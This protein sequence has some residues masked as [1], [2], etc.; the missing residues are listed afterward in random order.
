MPFTALHADLGRLNATLH[1]LGHGL[2]WSQIHKA[3]PRPPL[4]CPE[5]TWGLH[6]KVSKYG[7]RYFC[8]DP[9]RPPSCSL[10]NES[11]EHHMLKLEMATAIRDAGW[12][13]ELEVPA[14][15]GS[16]RADV[17]ATS[18]DGSQRMAWEA[19]LSPITVDDIRARTE[20]YMAEDIRVCWVSPHE[21]PPQWISAVPAIRVHAPQ[22]RG[23]GWVV[24]DGVAG[25]D[26]SEGGWNFREEQLGQFVRWVLHGQ[27]VSAES[28]PRYRR[29]YRV[30]DD[31]WVGFRR[32]R[33]WTSR[34]SVDAQ[35][36]HELMRQRQQA[37]REEREAREKERKEAEKWRQQ[38]LEERERA[39]RAEEAERLRKEREERDRIAWEETQRRWAEADARRAREKAE[40]EDRLA[41]KKA[42]QE[43]K[44]R[45]ALEAANAWWRRLSKPQTE[46]LFAAIVERAWREDKQWVEAPETPRMSREYAYGV[47]LYTRGKR[48]SRSLYGIVR[49]CPS[50]IAASPQ[51]AAEHALVRS[52]QEARELQEAGHEG[53]VTHFDLPE[54]EQLTMY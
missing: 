38:E 36:K 37:A 8:H 39:R 44:E 14:K 21:K 17:M 35:T 45:Q 12:F 4:T 29:V 24:D 52:A 41:R 19:Q 30:I 34:Q 49:P 43:E 5:C 33:W 6:A 26:Y 40:E 51:L 22:D 42:E 1:D 16:W 9:G 53:Q 23:Q 7:V 31:E 27:L 48:G 13:A 47:P 18:T 10:T 15:D 54:H 20:R 3:R 11:P 2:D 50:L 25:F 32:N 28:F 46:E